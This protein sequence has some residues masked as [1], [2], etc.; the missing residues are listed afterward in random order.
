[1]PPNVLIVPALKKL[2]SQ[3][4][5][6]IPQQQRDMFNNGVLLIFQPLGEIDLQSA[7]ISTAQETVEGQTGPVPCP[8]LHSQWE[9]EPKHL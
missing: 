1:M 7:F 8:E 3:I 4:W 5:E 6:Q 9:M 2:P